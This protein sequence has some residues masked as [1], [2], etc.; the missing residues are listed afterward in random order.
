MTTIVYFI[1]LCKRAVMGLWETEIS[2]Y[3]REPKMHRNWVISTHISI[4]ANHT[5]GMPTN[6]RPCLRPYL[7]YYSLQ[8]RTWDTLV[9]RLST[10]HYVFSLRHFFT[11]MIFATYPWT[12][13]CDY[14]A[15]VIARTPTDITFKLT[16]IFSDM[17]I[18]NNLTDKYYHCI[19]ICWWNGNFCL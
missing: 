18:W 8:F 5:R 4:L 12:H 15:C 9:S 6:W 17:F 14:I 1:G 19:N 13:N 3:S 10:N 11:H 2:H 7:Q 16:F